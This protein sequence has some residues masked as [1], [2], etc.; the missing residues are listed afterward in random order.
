MESYGVSIPLA[1]AQLCNLTLLIAWVA[2]AAV[3]LLR[4]RSAALT[5]GLQ[6]AWAALAVLVPVLG[7]LAVLLVR[8]GAERAGS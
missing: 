1:L 2:L 5:P 8:P 7:A 3:A 6:L 4:L